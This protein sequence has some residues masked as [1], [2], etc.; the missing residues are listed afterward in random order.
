MTEIK[1][2]KPYLL[3]LS[4][5]FNT[6]NNSYLEAYPVSKMAPEY[7]TKT[8]EHRRKRSNYCQKTIVRDER[9]TISLKARFLNG[10]G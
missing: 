9:L 10:K 8:I 6:L 3:V 7:S 1:N 5:F 4:Q 2:Y